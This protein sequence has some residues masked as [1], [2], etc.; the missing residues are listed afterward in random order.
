M[1]PD[2]PVAEPGDLG[3]T[4]GLR[5]LSRMIRKLTTEKD[6]APAWANHTLG[7]VEGGPIPDAVI[8]EM[9]GRGGVRHTLRE[10]YAGESDAIEI[11]RPVNLTAEEMGLLVDSWESDEGR[12]YGW[13]KLP[14]YSG[15]W[16]LDRLGWRN[17]YVF[18]RLVR[19][20]RVPVCH[21]SVGKGFFL[22]GRTFGAAHPGELTPDAM[23]DWVNAHEGEA[24]ELIWGGLGRD[25]A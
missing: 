1:R 21:Y 6:E 10:G 22:I 13:H 24:Y 25:L 5:R 4:H 7:V 20:D 11:W 18:R 17:A 23:H 15:D 3:F 16:L 2:F 14:A 8:V 12:P 19:I 9:L